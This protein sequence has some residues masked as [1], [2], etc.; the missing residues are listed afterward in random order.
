MTGQMSPF[1]IWR[2]RSRIWLP[3][4]GELTGSR[5][6]LSAI[7]S[8]GRSPS[9]AG[10]GCQLCLEN[11]PLHFLLAQAYHKEGL[12]D[13]ARL[14]TERYNA[15]TGAHSS[16]DTPLVAL[17]R[18][19]LE[20]GKSVDAERV[21]RQYLQVH[22]TSAEGHYLLGYILFKRQDATSSL[23]EYTEGAN[24]GPAG[25]SGS[26]GPYKSPITSC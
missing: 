5:Q 19:L 9:R 2:R 17:S 11:G 14:E 20:L 22:K 10:Q 4:T 16:P 6:G 13:K 3:A 21:T 26:G 24:H 18:S 8:T 12:A 1:G 7:E 15:L 25:C 23:A